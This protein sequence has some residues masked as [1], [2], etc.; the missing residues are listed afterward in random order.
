MMVLDCYVVKLAPGGPAEAAGLKLGMHVLQV[1]GQPVS[2]TPSFYDEYWKA[3][4]QGDGR[5]TLLAED[6]QGKHAS[7]TVIP[8]KTTVIVPPSGGRL[9]G[10]YGYINVQEFEGNSRLMRKYAN[11][12]QDLIRTT[13]A[14]DIKG[15]IVDLRLNGGGNMYPMIAG[16]GALFGDGDLGSFISSTGAD[17]WGY[18]K[19]S[20]IEGGHS[21]VGIRPYKLLHKGLPIAVLIAGPTASSGEAVAISFIGLNKTVLVGGPTQGL[22]TANEFETL[23]DGTVINLCEAVEADRTGKKYGVPIRPEIFVRTS[24]AKY[25]TDEDPVVLAAKK[26]ID[27]Q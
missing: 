24:W 14:S 20:A 23:S 5:M 1:N 4:G 16:L 3:M 12:I 22:T 17:K 11:Q 6:R 2:D 25:G 26:W 19:G 13:D 27:E 7:Y 21:V 9:D 18:K 10:G 15:W 8:G